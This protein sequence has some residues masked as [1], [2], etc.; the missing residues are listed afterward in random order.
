M[1]ADLTALLGA[2]R[3]ETGWLE[4][5]LDRLDDAGWQR[6]TPAPGWRI[7]D[8]IAHL[9]F[10]DEAATTALVDPERFVAEAQAAAAEPVGVVDAIAQRF[11]SRPASE[12]ADWFR[13]A[14]T[15]MI[16]AFEN[17]DA[18]AR[19][20]WY[21]PAMSVASSL[22][23][24]IMETWAHGQDVAD[25]LGVAH[26]V[27]PA[28]E[29]VAHIGARA[30]PNSFRANGLAVPDTE[31]RVELAAPD[32][33]RWVFGDPVATEWVRGP[34]LDFALVVTQRRH[35]D[36]T[37]LEAHGPVAVQW[38]RIAQAFAGPPG[39]GRAPGARP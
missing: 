16:E 6:A 8:Q 15:A 19:V 34:A 29:A 25:A 36:D 9:A 27:T 5:L 11:A 39:P 12:V 33:S 31:V 32:G 38:L 37:S 13:T 4:G 18:S 35:V 1:P 28:L 22:T 26:P 3:A 10:F 2:L 23:A 7:Q 21:G 20:P 24:R 14:R 30:R 17:A